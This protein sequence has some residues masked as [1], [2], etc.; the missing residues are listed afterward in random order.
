MECFFGPVFLQVLQRTQ[1]Q[2][3]GSVNTDSL[4]CAQRL[5]MG[6]LTRSREDQPS[7]PV[8]AGQV[9][10]VVGLPGQGPQGKAG[11]GAPACFLLDFLA[12]SGSTFRPIDAKTYTALNHYLVTAASA[13]VVENCRLCL[14]MHP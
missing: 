12:D 10:Q 7:A 13:D 4:R 9:L 3:S 11:H 6:R 2:R 14:G 1:L 5:G 8:D